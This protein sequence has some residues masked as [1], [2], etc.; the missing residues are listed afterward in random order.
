MSIFTNAVLIIIAGV[1]VWQANDS[2]PLGE[3]VRAAWVRSW[4]T[5]L[6]AIAAMFY[7]AYT[8]V[9]D[10]LRV[11]ASGFMEFPSLAIV[12]DALVAVACAMLA[13]TTR[14]AYW[15]ARRAEQDRGTSSST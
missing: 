4:I 3:R 12:W 10:M 15:L 2:R 11:V 9:A 8:G 7:A 5:T 1:L 13:R 6:T 14:S